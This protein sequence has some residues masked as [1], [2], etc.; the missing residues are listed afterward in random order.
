MDRL[1]I[2]FREELRIAIQFRLLGPP[3]EGASPA[4]DQPLNLIGGR[5]IA[6]VCCIELTWQDRSVQTTLEIIKLGLSYVDFEWTN[7]AVMNT[8]PS[9]QDLSDIEEKHKGDRKSVV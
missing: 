8:S 5:S 9:T 4:V 3:V 6:P 1:A 2:D 7:S